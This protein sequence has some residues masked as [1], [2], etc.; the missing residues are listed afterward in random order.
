M[1]YLSD[2][3]SKRAALLDAAGYGWIPRHFI[4]DDLAAGL[5]IRLDSDPAEWTYHPQIITRAGHRLGR[6]GELFL[7]TLSSGG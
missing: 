4:E 5:L 7:E 1:V 2:F 6:G 3:H